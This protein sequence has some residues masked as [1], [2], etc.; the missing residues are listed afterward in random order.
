MTLCVGSARP[1]ISE[2]Q[3]IGKMIR[4]TKVSVVRLS[5]L[6]RYPLGAFWHAL[7]HVF[8]PAV[9]TGDTPDVSP[10]DRQGSDADV[11]RVGQR[12]HPLKI[13]GERPSQQLVYISLKVKLWQRRLTIKVLKKSAA[14]LSRVRASLR[15]EKSMRNGW[16]FRFGDW[17]FPFNP[18]ASV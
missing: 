17:F 2:M 7:G 8:L 4:Y 16:V 12:A 10:A 18:Q 5:R 15:E 14:A 1:H 9:P 11:H 6:P 13:R 3:M